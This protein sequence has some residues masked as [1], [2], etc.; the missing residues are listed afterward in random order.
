MTGN[1]KLEWE[2]IDRYYQKHLRET[3]YWV[4]MS[5]PRMMVPYHETA[6]E[7]QNRMIAQSCV[8]RELFGDPT[9]W[10]R[11]RKISE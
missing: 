2:L 5:Q 6:Q 3:D 9:P 1:E 4:Y 8:A 11:E 10:G 7:Y